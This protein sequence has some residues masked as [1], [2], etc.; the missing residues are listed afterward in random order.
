MLCTLLFFFALIF[1]PDFV[2]Q[3]VVDSFILG[4]E[5]DITTGRVARIVPVL[6]FL[7]TNLWLGNLNS[8]IGLGIVHIFCLFKIYQYG[9]IFS[10]PI[11]ILYFYFPIF[12]Y[13]CI[14][15]INNYPYELIG[16]F[17]LI[18]PYIISTQ[19]YT[20][21]FGP[22]TATVFNYILF[23]YSLQNMKLQNEIS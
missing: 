10:M 6:H 1:I 16:L 3:Y 20:F 11:L 19:E 22:G 7:S 12:D 21:P 23:G 14:S 4:R 17:A 8:N 5:D 18:I 2:Y 13:K 9:I 15:R